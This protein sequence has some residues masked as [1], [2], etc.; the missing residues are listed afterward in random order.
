MGSLEQRFLYFVFMDTEVNSCYH[1][2]PGRLANAIYMVLLG[3]SLSLSRLQLAVLTFVL[4]FQFFLQLLIPEF[5]IL[6]HFL[7][8]VTCVCFLMFQY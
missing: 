4:L 2:T 7:G 1:D 6:Q 3:S 8:E 5:H